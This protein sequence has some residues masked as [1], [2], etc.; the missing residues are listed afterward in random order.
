MFNCQQQDDDNE[1]CPTV[2]E[3]K[4]VSSADA[5]IPEFL[6]AACNAEDTNFKVDN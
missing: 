5:V 3:E 4:F 6:L 1:Q 2:P